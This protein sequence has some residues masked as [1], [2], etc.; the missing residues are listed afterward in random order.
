[1][2]GFSLPNKRSDRVVLEAN[3]GYWDRT[4]FPRLRRIIFDNTL[5]QDEAMALVKTTEGRVDLVT[6]L[7]PID[8]LR[9]AQSDFAKV[10]KRRESFN[11]VFGMFNM[12]RVKSPWRD[13]RVRQ[14]AN[15]AI[16]R[17]DV[18]QYAARGN[19]E[20][21]PALV[22][23]QE[24]G[25][26]AELAPYAF[27]PIKARGLLGDAGYPGG[28]PITVIAPAE[29]EAQATVV[30]KMLDA[31][32]FK[33]RLQVLDPVA[34]NQKTILSHLDRPAEQQE[35]DIAL[36]VDID[37]ENFPPF[38]LYHYYALD[39]PYDWVLEERELQKLYGQVGRTTDRKTQADLIQQME[40]HSSEHAYFLFLYNPI[41]LFAINKA[42]EFVPYRVPI[43]ILNE[44]SVT[45]EHWSVRRAQRREGE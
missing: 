17:E 25:Y 33:V 3:L 26:N 29:L 13:V 19:G 16:N 31:S 5:S 37:V 24:F 28:L 35:W 10:V 34:F 1:M 6:E 2:D 12:R 38:S 22:S 14:A 9:V 18:V 39:G 7:K 21:V 4:R 20:I 11:V 30:S 32:G 44:A 27:D 41:Q 23:P 43:L 45:D 40:R 8:T 36:T 15:L 42:V